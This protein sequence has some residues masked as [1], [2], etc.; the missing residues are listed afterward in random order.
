[1]LRFS[2]NYIFPVN[3][4]PIRNG[5]VVLDSKN[6]VVDI[7]DPKGNEKE[8]ESMEFHNGVIV[9]GFVNTHCHLELSHLKGKLKQT[10]GIASFVSQIRNLRRVETIE[11]TDSINQAI[12]ILE[13]NGTVAIGDICNTNDSFNAKRKS[14]IYFHNFIE[15]FGLNSSE[16]GKKMSSALKI[17]NSIYRTK[18]AKSLTPHSTYSISDEL[19]RMINIELKKSSSIA[20]IHFGESLQEYQI[21]KN[22]TGQLAENFNALKFPINLPDCSNPFEVVERFIPRTSQTLFIHNTFSTREE[23]LQLINHFD[24]SFFVLCPSSNLFIEGKLPDL[25]MLIELGANLAIG[26]DSLASSDTLSVFDQ[27]IILLNKFPEVS[28]TDAIK[29][30]TLNGAK[31]LNIDSIYGSFEIGKSPGLNLITDFDFNTMKPT[32]KSRVKRLI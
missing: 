13:K 16:A 24:D 28:F 25:P 12:S 27:V 30:A 1:M 26:T 32:S 21:L 5:I 3:G 29:W 10:D 7:V 22:R 17:F 6:I 4:K 11:I 20:S 15:L 18:G 8:Y 23:V 9:P 2:A 19:W 14:D 31:A